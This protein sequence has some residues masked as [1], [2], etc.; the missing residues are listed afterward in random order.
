MKT[1]TQI[2][3]K[4]EWKNST[5]DQTLLKFEA[6]IF[7]FDYT[8]ADSS[9][10]VV[11]CINFAL[12]ELDLPPVSSERACQT[13]GLSLSDTFIKLA[14]Q[15]H[16]AKCNEFVGLFI[17]RADEVM[18]GLTVLFETVPKTVELLKNH[19]IALGIVSTKFRRRIETILRRENLLEPF[20]V[21]IGGEDVSEHKPDPR[22]LLTAIEKLKSLPENSLYV[23]DSLT[24][25]ETAKR[26]AVPFVAVLSGVTPKDAFKDYDVYGIIKSIYDLPRLIGG[27]SCN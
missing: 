13:I 4:F 1:Q 22:G 15:Q 2:L 6:I 10:G 3:L 17:K 26:A 24:D 7:D 19:G 16:I 21:I 8:L 20:D 12:N 5:F 25:A 9:R 11:E 27:E 14:A 23:G 18:A